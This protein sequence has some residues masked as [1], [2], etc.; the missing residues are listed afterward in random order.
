MKKKL[1]YFSLDF[2]KDFYF[3]FKFDV[4]LIEHCFDFKNDVNLNLEYF[5]FVVE[6]SFTTNISK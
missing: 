2:K 4:T 6:V 5:L 1:R 3:G